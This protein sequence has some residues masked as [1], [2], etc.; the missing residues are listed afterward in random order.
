MKRT[1]K[2][3][4]ILS[5]WEKELY[6][7]KTMK[8]K[9]TLTPK[10]TALFQTFIEVFSKDTDEAVNAL[11]KAGLAQYA[12]ATSIKD[13]LD[14]LTQRFNALEEENKA[15]R[16][17]DREMSDFFITWAADSDGFQGLTRAREHFLKCTEILETDGPVAAERFH[18]EYV[19][20]LYGVGTRPFGS[21]GH[22][23]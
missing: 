5:H 17:K 14:N 10:T 20:K 12:G 16:K 1:K 21:S 8:L 2:V 22:I 18:R 23:N 9:A 15:R 6:G 19:D 7:N 4:A 11:L 3:D 13:Q